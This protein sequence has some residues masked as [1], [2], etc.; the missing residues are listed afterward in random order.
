MHSETLNPPEKLETTH[1]FILQAI[2][3]SLGCPVLEM[4]LRVDDLDRLRA[5]LGEE[6]S[7]DAELR[8]IYSIGRD[9][10]RAIDNQYGVRFEPDGRECRLA[11]AHS[12]RDAPY[13]I[14][15]GFELFLMLEGVKPF[16]KFA[17]EYPAEVDEFPE[18]ALFE[19]HVQ[20]GTLIKRV[21]IEPFEKPIRTSSG[22]VFEG[23]RQVFY[24][25]RGEEWRID[26]YN[27]L[28]R[29][30]AHGPWN[31]TLERLEGSLLGYTDQ[32]NDWWIAHIR[33]QRNLPGRTTTLVEHA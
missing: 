11:R 14:H 9:E 27:L 28:R 17:V 29:Q 6:A 16:A 19:P 33:H 12:I 30:L 21:M 8:D 18:E 10:L 24:A 1:R 4:M 15:T 20:A 31:D 22:S 2:D 5:I 3:P 25:R 26:A 32:Q 13:L 23:L 7:D